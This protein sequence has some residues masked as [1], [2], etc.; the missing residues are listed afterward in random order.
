MKTICAGSNRA[1]PHPKVLV[2]SH[3]VLGF[4]TNM[5]KTM[6]DFFTGWPQDE[7]AQ[8]YFYNEV[9][10]PGVC[11]CYF[12]ITDFDMLESIFK[13]KN[14]GMAF[15]DKIIEA[16]GMFAKSEAGVQASF[17]QLG[18]KRKPYGYFFRN[19]LWKTRKWKTREL[20]S[21]IDEYNP[22]IV[23]YAAGDYTFSMKIALNISR[24]KNIPLVTYFGDDF[25]FLENSTKLSF[26]EQV[27]RENFSRQ[28]EE[29]FSYLTTFTAATDKLN[30]RYSKYF[31]KTGY[32]IL[33]SAR[34]LKEKAVEVRG[35]E[36]LKISYIGTLILNRWRG[37]V[38][39]GRCLRKVG[40]VLDVYSME[41]DPKILSQLTIVNGIR[42]QGRIP[43]EDVGEVIRAS[44]IV[45]HVEAMDWMS[46][47]L[48]KYSL[49]SKIGD[50]LGSGV[51]LFA[52]GPS[53]V[54]SIEYLRENDVACVC[55]SENELQD[56]LEGILK[57]AEL[58]Q[59]YINNALKLAAARHDLTTNA[60]SFYEMVRDAMGEKVNTAL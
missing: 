31:G 35:N 39:I 21:W 54:A 29:L 32:A 26:F 24:E 40:L 38:D 60:D 23:F 42:F 58:R 52:Y 53:D 4:S 51:C 50:Y 36:I 41:K 59:H 45:V 2:I 7:I 47:R 30:E 55:R 34:I 13:F 56:K 3:N 46:K 17:Y 5:G 8:L 11:Q 37:L 14:P 22:E 19:L 27:N 48:T 25:Y 57:N 43:P 49:S 12:R 10:A 15:C 28:L 33:N 1:K 6:M 44:T 9:P 16:D 20:I 18:A